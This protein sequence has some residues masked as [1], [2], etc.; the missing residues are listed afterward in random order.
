VAAVQ[1]HLRSAAPAGNMD[2]ENG[3]QAAALRLQSSTVL[4][5][6]LEEET[7]MSINQG[8]KYESI[9]AKV[10]H[11]VYGRWPTDED[12][13][14]AIVVAMSDFFTMESALD[15]EAMAADWKTE[16]GEQMQ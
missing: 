1:A 12:D 16:H 7:N 14:E 9:I 6:A 3:L 5:P 10:F 11:T 4:L 15:V 13:D 2:F 8:K